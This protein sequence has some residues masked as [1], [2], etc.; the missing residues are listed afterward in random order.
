M[1]RQEKRGARAIPVCVAGESALLSRSLLGALHRSRNVRLCSWEEVSQENRAGQR[2]EAVLVIDQ[3]A[4]PPPLAHYLQFLRLRFPTGGQLIVGE[5]SSDDSLCHL[6]LIGVR[7]LEAVKESRC[8]RLVC[9]PRARVE[10]RAPNG[11]TVVASA[12]RMGSSL[13]G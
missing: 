4:I 12:Y 6:L 9:S 11:F 7:G 2:Y 10:V 8:A 5:E 1:I 13:F 3:R